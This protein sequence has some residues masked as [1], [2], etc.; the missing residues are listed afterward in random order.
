MAR[1][2]A[3]IAARPACSWTKGSSTNTWPWPTWCSTKAVFH[4]KPKVQKLTYDGTAERY[5]HGLMTAYK[6]ESGKF[7]E[8]NVPAVVA[9]LKEPLGW[10]PQPNFDQYQSKDRRYVPHGPCTT[11][12]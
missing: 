9:K 2:A 3:S 4:E 10:I 7:V 8:T 1:S 12:R 6:D 5:V 11:G